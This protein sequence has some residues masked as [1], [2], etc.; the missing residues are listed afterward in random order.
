MKRGHF[1]HS[2][3]FLL[4]FSAHDKPTLKRNIE[5]HGAVAGDYNLGDLSYTLANKR[6]RFNSRA[7]AVAS[8]AT[9]SDAFDN[10]L[11]EFTF[12]E[13]KKAP[14]IGFVFTGQGAQWAQMSSEL[15]TY[16][17][18]FLRSIR[19]LDMV[20]ENLEDTP[21]WTL[22]D[23]L[24]GK[25]ETSRINEAEFSQPLC[26]AIQVALV[27]LLRLWGITPTVTCGHSSGEIAAAYAAGLLS[28]SEA[29][30]LAYYRG[31]VVKD[32]NTDGAML[33]V[34]LGAEAVEPHLERTI[35]EVIVACHN[36]P[37]SV[38]LS[39]DANTLETLQAD[40][41]AESVFA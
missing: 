11:R 31:K 36:S 37:D 22:E 34:G 12:G 19:Y 17:P 26:T 28:A 6:T 2:R 4:P 35:G 20:L 5:A 8:Y 30:V 3:P 16:Y 24:L 7:F 27:Q 10:G 29:I 32:I 25:A 33:A 9:I 15:M 13:K 18:S 41:T 38:T 1:N 39:G 21:D 14:T 23:A 40:L